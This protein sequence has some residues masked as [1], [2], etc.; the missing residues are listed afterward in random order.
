MCKLVIKTCLIAF[1]LVA[2]NLGSA[3]KNIVI[4]DE[5]SANSDMLNVKMGSQKFGRIWNFRFGEYAVVKSKLGW[6]ITK[7][8]GNFWGTKSA[9]TT[10]EK[11]SFILCNQKN[12][13]AIVNAANKIVAQSLN[14]IEILPNFH[15]GTNELVKGENLFSAQIIVNRDTINN[16]A[17]F[18]KKTEGSQ[19]GS[20]FLA[21]L[22]NGQ[23]DIKIYPASS[24]KDTENRMLPARGYEFVENGQAISALQYLGSGALGLNKSIVWLSKNLDEQMK[25]ILAAAMT[26]VLQVETTNLGRAFGG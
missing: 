16:W 23:R 24:N 25:L 3:Q 12:D 8:K 2:P 26:A 19:T 7:S 21:F 17:I 4:S 15:W 20:G 13:S 18:I 14:E 5:L 6:T 9:S 11:F 1:F 10:S 22:T